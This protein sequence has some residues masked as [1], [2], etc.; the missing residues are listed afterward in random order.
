VIAVRIPIAFVYFITCWISLAQAQPF[1]RLEGTVRS[2]EDQKPLIGANVVLVGTVRGTTSDAKGQYNIPNIPPGQYSV[3]V[4]LVG[5]ERRTIASIEISSGHTTQLTVELQPSPVQAAPVVVTASIIDARTLNARNTVTL[6]DA[7][8]YVP[9][10]NITKSQVSIRGST[11]YSY[12]AGT[13]VLM[14]V[15]GLPLLSGDTHE[16][17]WEEIPTNEIER[18]E[19][20]KGAGSALYGSSAMG[21]VINVITKTPPESTDVRLRTYGGL[22]GQPSYNAWQ[23]ST[24][25]RGFGGI[26]AS[27]Q[28]RIDELRVSA[29]GS[30]TLD[31]GY[32]QNDYWKRWNAWT[33]LG[34][35]FT[36]Q[37]SLSVS[38]NLLDQHRGNFLYWKDINHVLQP[39]DDQLNQRVSSFRWNLGTRYE[40]SISN[41]LSQEVRMS[42]LRSRWD[43][44]I[45]SAVDSTGSHS[46]SDFA[47]GD[48]QIN[49][50]LSISQFLTGGLSG[51]FSRT[52]AESIFGKH[53]AH[54]E[55]IFLQDEIVLPEN[56]RLTLGAR[57][58]VNTISGLASVGQFNPKVGLVYHPSIVTTLRASAGRGFRAPAIAE[59]FTTTEAGGIVVLPNPDLKPERSWSYEVGGSQLISDI[60]SFDASLFRNEFWDLI[61]PAFSPDGNVRFQ[62]VT[63]AHV[64]GTELT[65]IVDLF[66]RL[67]RTQVGYTYIYPEDA[68]TGD[69]LK[70][71]SRHLLYVSNQLLAY[72]LAVGIDFRYISKMERIDEQLVT[73]GVIPN[74]DQ[75]VPAYVMDVRCSY[76]WTFGG[77]PLT[78]SFQINNLFQ[79]YYVDFVGNLA[80]IRNYALTLEMRL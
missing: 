52:A 53:T 51:S 48:W 70:Y 45:P 19:V 12:G 16:I 47:V 56:L 71:R 25:P 60:L 79:Y 28:R 62:N 10:V 23:W 77:V 76:D 29:G 67:L 41:N 69:I 33:R 15:D 13:R 17:I 63:R 80:P 39:S 37:Q 38:F 42:W 64:T 75:R 20:V 4:S 26:S 35:T 57:T 30:R 1:G 46:V 59:V 31:D 18:V 9:G 3:T 2:A 68:T 32:R 78:A 6:N 58:D 11:G 34:Y 66:N 55:A 36:P 72:L 40:Q 8:E 50:Q 65:V 54:S 22:Y 7:L 5:F 74:G 43:D 21:G 44:N 61:E 27:Y 49:Y 73:L 24:D 14:L